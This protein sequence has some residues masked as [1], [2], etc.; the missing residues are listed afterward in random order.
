M[1]A[2]PNTRGDGWGTRRSGPRSLEKS[3]PDLPRTGSA[4]RYRGAKKKNIYFWLTAGLI[5]RKC[6]ESPTITNGCSGPRLFAFAQLFGCPHRLGLLQAGQQPSVDPST[7]H[8]RDIKLPRHPPRFPCWPPPPRD[9]IVTTVKV[10]AFFSSHFAYGFT[11][12]PCS[13]PIWPLIVSIL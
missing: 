13:S 7:W 4:K 11:N 10:Y 12:L 5:A 2:A 3:G 9:N 8:S 6:L 1:G